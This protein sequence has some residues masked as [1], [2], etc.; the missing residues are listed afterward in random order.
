MSPRSAHVSTRATDE[1]VIHDNLHDFSELTIARALLK[2]SVEFILPA[3]YRDKP[4]VTGE[5]RVVG[6]YALKLT[7]SKDLLIVKFLSP[8]SLRDTTMQMY[9]TILEPKRGL[10][11]GA[12]LTVLTAMKHLPHHIQ[13][14]HDIGVCQLSAS[15]VTRAMIANFN[16]L[17]AGLIFDVSHVTLGDNETSEQSPTTS[18]FNIRSAQDPI[19]YT[20]AT[21]VSKHHGQAMR[22]SMRTEWIKSQ[23]LEMQDFGVVVYFKRF[24]APPSVLKIKFSAPASAI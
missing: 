11:Q 3:H 10:G 22:S 20:K 5:M 21:P 8:Q 18:D 16:S 19:G 17:Q 24:C 2:H 9:C 23:N 14:L 7:K 12:D 4:D 6:V 15:G 13:S 1:I